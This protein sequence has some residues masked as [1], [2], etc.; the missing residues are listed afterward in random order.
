MVSRKSHLVLVISA[1]L[2]VVLSVAPVLCQEEDPDPN[3]PTPVLLSMADS[4][5]ALA[6]PAGKQRPARSRLSQ[7]SSTAFP[8]GGKIQIFITNVDLMKGEGA[9]AFRVYAEDRKGRLFRFPVLDLQP[10]PETNWIYAVTLR[11]TDEIGFWE[12]PTADGD[13]FIYITWRGLAS[14]RVKLGLE[15]QADYPTTLMQCPLLR[16]CSKLTLC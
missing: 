5:R 9:N 14:N 15:R 1:F 4:T 13:L 12:P 16:R 7:P 2:F 3:S 8:A 10:L 11:L 6:V